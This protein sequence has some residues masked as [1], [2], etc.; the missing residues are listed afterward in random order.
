MFAFINDAGC[1]SS[2]SLEPHSTKHKNKEVEQQV[3]QDLIVFVS[4]WLG[5]I[6]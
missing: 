1:F 6:H 2:A 3:I 4:N 5:S